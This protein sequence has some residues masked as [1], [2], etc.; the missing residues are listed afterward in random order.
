MENLDHCV[1]QALYFDS[2][3]VFVFKC[4]WFSM[5]IQRINHCQCN[6]RW[7]MWLTATLKECYDTYYN[8]MK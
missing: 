3:L 8:T 4:V 6:L 2:A 5:C 1:E 7:Q